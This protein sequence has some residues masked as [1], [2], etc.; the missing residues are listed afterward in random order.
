MPGA[1]WLLCSGAGETGFAAKGGHNDEPHNHNDVGSFIFY[2]K[3]VM[4]LLDTGA[5]EYTRDYFGDK[6]YAI[7]CNR[8]EGHNLPII[9]GQGQKAGKEFAAGN[10]V[11]ESNG[12]M[13]LDLAPAY[14]IPGLEKLERYFRFDI[15]TGVLTLRDSFVFSSG[16]LPIIE[17]FI[18]PAEPRIT[19]DGYSITVNGTSCSLCC[20]KKIIP[21]VTTVNYRNHEGE[22]AQVFTVNFHFHP[23]ENLFPVEFVIE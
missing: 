7:F 8:S 21:Q 18:L 23:R 22:D 20:S 10:C 13:S 3:G 17:R 6:R 5:G 9:A 16:G 12:S 15:N 2:K 14:D 4:F 1:Q 19:N 11:I